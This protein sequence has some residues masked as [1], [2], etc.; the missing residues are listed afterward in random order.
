MKTENWICQTM[1]PGV[2][3]WMAVGANS[4]LGWTICRRQAVTIRPTV[5]PVPNGLT[6]YQG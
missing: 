5:M 1:A 2:R 3:D 6:Q 4:L